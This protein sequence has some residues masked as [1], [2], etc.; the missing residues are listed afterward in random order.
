MLFQQVNQEPVRFL[1]IHFELISV[2]AQEDIR[3]KKRD[4]FVPI[5][6][7]MIHDQ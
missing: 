6:K 4:P 2:Q 3:G 7:R 1:G 5:N